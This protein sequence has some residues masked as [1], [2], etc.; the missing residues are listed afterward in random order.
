MRDSSWT[1]ISLVLLAVSMITACANSNDTNL[2]IATGGLVSQ[3]LGIS[4]GDA[5]TAATGEAVAQGAL[6]NVNT[7]SYQVADAEPTS[8]GE[9]VTTALAAGGLV[10][11]AIG[12]ANNNATTAAVGGAVAAGAMGQ[13]VPQYGAGAAFG[14]VGQSPVA[15]GGAQCSAAVCNQILAQARKMQ[16]EAQRNGTS[17]QGDHFRVQHA[18]L[19]YHYKQC[20]NRAR[21]KGAC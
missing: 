6:A 19:M 9:D 18:N 1:P 21:Q 8:S 3:A 7:E 4:N 15:A 16:I 5:L 17:S 12:L 10:T 14:A 11:Q 13:S 2:A 20:R